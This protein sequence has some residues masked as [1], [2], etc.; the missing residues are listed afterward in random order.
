MWVDAPISDE[1][2]VVL[3]FEEGSLVRNALPSTLEY[4]GLNPEAAF[5]RACDN[6]S[7]AFQAGHFELGLATLTDGIQVGIARGSWM[8]PAGG[9]MVRNHYEN[10]VEHFGVEQFAGIVLHQQMMVT[11]P[12]DERTV[13]SSML[14]ELVDEQFTQHRK[15]IS[16]SWL[17]I[18]G[19]WPRPYPGPRLF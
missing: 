7:K 19:G 6:L 9:L 13:A 4:M 12:V 5:D 2:K 14:R 15:P 8:A 16:R 3:A 11:F 10:L 17:V 18:D 1:V